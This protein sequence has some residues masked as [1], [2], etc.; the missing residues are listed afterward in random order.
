MDKRLLASAQHRS[1]ASPFGSLPQDVVRQFI[2]RDYFQRVSPPW[3][4]GPLETDLFD[5]I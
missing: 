1:Q 3:Q 5:G 4:G 2:S